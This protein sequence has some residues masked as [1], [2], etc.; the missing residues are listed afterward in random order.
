MGHEEQEIN[1]VKDG[2]ATRWSGEWNEEAVVWRMMVVVK[3]AGN[4]G[5]DGGGGDGGGEVQIEGL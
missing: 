4:D 3:K 5:G 2:S 1:G